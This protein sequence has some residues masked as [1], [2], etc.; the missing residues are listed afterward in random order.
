MEA[1][2][3]IKQARQFVGLSQTQLAEAAST[4]QSAI[5]AYETNAKQPSV[6]TLTRIV[7]ATGAHLHWTLT[8]GLL[9]DLVQ[10]VSEALIQ[11]DAEE[12][13]RLVCDCSVRLELLNAE[14]IQEAILNDPGT[15]GKRNWDAMVGGVIER[16]ANR[17][18][19]PVPPWTKQPQRFAKQFWFVADMP[20]LRA[21]AL[22]DTPA[23]LSNRGVFLHE[24]SLTGL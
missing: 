9:A 22:V 18:R 20:S 11:N 15:T 6:A 12:A 1:G 2:T 3:I 19:L 14:A 24:S 4:S 7:N 16:V 8:R 23:E 5:A 21:S 17:S 13:L 10:G